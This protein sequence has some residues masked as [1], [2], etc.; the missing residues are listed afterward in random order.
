[1]TLDELHT[2]FQA[3]RSSKPRI[4]TP[5][6]EERHERALDIIRREAKAILE[7]EAA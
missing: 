3:L 6:A 1:M 7:E 5:E 4:N 2:I